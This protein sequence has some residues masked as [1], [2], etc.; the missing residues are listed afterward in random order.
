MHSIRVQ[1]FRDF[2]CRIWPPGVF[3]LS[4][5][6]KKQEKSKKTQTNIFPVHNHTV[7]KTFNKYQFK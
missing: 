7:I 5:N 1:N 2:Y 4:K 6:A 3:E